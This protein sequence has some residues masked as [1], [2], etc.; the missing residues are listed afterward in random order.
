MVNTELIIIIAAAI[1]LV[2]FGKKNKEKENNEYDKLTEK[3]DFAGIT[4][5]HYRYAIIWSVLASL[6]VTTTVIAILKDGF[7]IKSVKFI[8]GAAL[9]IYATV[10]NWKKW[11]DS[12]KVAEAI[13]CK[14][15]P[16]E[17]K[18]IWKEE[19]D[20][21]LLY[22]IEEYIYDNKCTIDN[23]ASYKVILN[24]PEQIVFV[25]YNLDICIMDEGFQCFFE[26]Y[27]DLFNDAL[28]AFARK[29]GCNDVAT[30]CETAVQIYTGN[31]Q[32]EEKSEQLDTRCNQP[33]IAL[34]EHPRN[35]I[36]CCAEYA[37]SHKEY[38]FL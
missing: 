14:L 22:Q 30:I 20:E 31:L 21:E 28:A 17:I 5:T 19:D 33:Y 37:R 11:A 7:S 16:E 6:I 25:L 34:K 18:S 9:S 3:K 4:K 10:T 38:F 35:I 13:S 29:V 32:E 15:S 26:T 2:Y 8:L 27:S 36:T 12:N 23:W 24:E 1:L